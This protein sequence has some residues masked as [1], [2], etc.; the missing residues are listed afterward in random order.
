MMPNTKGN[1]CARNRESGL[2]QIGNMRRFGALELRRFIL[3]ALCSAFLVN[4]SHAQ[5]PADDIPV[6]T[7]DD[8][9]RLAIGNN[10]SLKIA[11]LDVD[12]SK[13]QVTE[14]KTNRLPVFK[15]YLFAS[16]DL[17]S[18][19]FTFKEGTLG[20]INGVPFPTED[21]KIPL[22][23]GL[24][25]SALAEATQPLTQLYKINLAIREQVLGQDQAS[26]QYRAQRQALVDNVKQGYYGIVQS[27]SAL[28]AAQASLK[29]Y[30]EADRV[31]QQYLGQEAVLKSDTLDV[32]AKLAQ[33]KYQVIQLQDQV[34]TRK[35]HLNDLLSRDL[36]IDFRT[37]PIPAESPEEMD[38]KVARQKA[39]L[40]RPE[41]AQAQLGIQKAG[42][43]RKLAKA[44]YI[45]D[46]GFAIHYFSPLT[47]D[48]L[49]QN[50][51]SAGLELS[52]EPFDWGRR[53]DEVKLKDIAIDQ[54]RYQLQ[55]VQSQVLL[56][57]NNRFRTLRESRALLE[58]AQASLAAAKQKLSEVTDKFS[59]EAVLLRDVL[60]QQAA[61]ASANNNYQQALL[62]F[63]SAQADFQKALG[64]E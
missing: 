36:S 23:Q 11:G 32:K 56:D 14:A 54:S 39:L 28:D 4:S 16:K 48:I 52:W 2:E 25:G 51:F 61:V 35:E 26:Q 21:R 46:V 27:E 19:E 57:V 15:T 8:A 30:Q 62:S 10:L 13:W 6:L 18:P 42:F 38:L 40:Q 7:V 12:K 29:Q 59:K 60:Q 55:Q 24:T 45:P 9:V 44:Q 3:I 41:I 34:Q 50:I 43:D 33:A 5:E 17:N 1:T 58:V 37:Q 22:S 63:W 47:S 64:E 49:P 20:P 53:K 31:A